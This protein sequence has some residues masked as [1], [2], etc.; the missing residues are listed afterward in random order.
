[1]QID[2][3]SCVNTVVNT[4]TNTNTTILI[5]YNQN[6]TSHS[7]LKTHTNTA[8]N[9]SVSIQCT[10][11]TRLLISRYQFNV[12]LVHRLYYKILYVIDEEELELDNRWLEN[13]KKIEKKYD[14]FYKDTI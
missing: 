11:S 1:M 8:F 2:K 5:L 10:F 4:N 9:L 13:L 3:Q 12:H 6:N 7:D 14:L